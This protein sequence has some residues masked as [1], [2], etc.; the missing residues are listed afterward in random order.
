MLTASAQARALVDLAMV[1]RGMKRFAL[2]YPAVPYGTELANA[3]WDEVE[4]RGGEV[5]AAESYASDRTTFTPLVQ[6][7]VGKLFLDERQDWRD[8]VR[9]IGENERDPFRR[10]K[11]VEKAREK[12]DPITDFDAIFIPDGAQN[13]KLIAP[14]LAVEDI[15]T[16]TCEPN[17]VARIKKTTGRENLQPVQLLGSNGWG[18][19]PSLFDVS[20][21]GA[22]RHV[23]CAI[24]VDGFWAGSARPQT[25]AFVEAFQKK[26]EGATPSILEASA[27]D[28]AGI[29]RRILETARPQTRPA[30]RDA[31][32]TVKGFPGATG[33]ITIG[34]RRTAE[35]TLFFLTVDR[36]G[37]RELTPQE[38]ATPGAG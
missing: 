32:S 22:G 29:A 23:R 30:F 9:E 38:L 13:V 31:L 11:A 7:M 26:F 34:P 18:F 27:Y 14:A 35:K 15:V 37:L 19:D 8:T 21:G 36:N 6:G 20:P 28:A 16:Q 10:R 1:R 24:Y 33:D 5:R 3:F 17:E 4:A 12:L 25:K 2:L